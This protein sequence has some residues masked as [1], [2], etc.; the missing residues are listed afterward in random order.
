[1]VHQ[2]PNRTPAQRHVTAPFVQR[3]PEGAVAQRYVWTPDPLIITFAHDPLCVGIYV[4][5]ARLAYAAKGAV[6]LAARDLA[7]WMGH[8]TDA[9][10]AA[11]MRRIVKLTQAGWLAVERHSAHKHRLL[12]TWGPDQTGTIRSWCVD[13]DDCGKPAHLRGRRVPLALFDDYLGRLD[14]QPGHRRA[15][16]SR[17]LS[18]PLLDLTDIG[19][20]AIGLRA[21]IA[22]TPRLRHL[23]L[24]ANIG[25]HRLPQCETLLTHAAR[26]H[27]T[28]LDA[29]SVVAVQLTALGQ[30]RLA[31]LGRAD[32]LGTLPISGSITGSV[33]GSVA[34]SATGSALEP[35]EVPVPAQQDAEKGTADTPTPVIAWDDR[36]SHEQTNHDSTASDSIG[37]GGDVMPAA[38]GHTE[39][40]SPPYLDTQRAIPCPLSPLLD[41]AIASGH[42]ALNPHRPLPPGEWHELLTLQQTHGAVNLLIWQARASRRAQPHPFGITPGYYRACAVAQAFT[43]AQRVVPVADRVTGSA[44]STEA[45]HTTRGKFDPVCDALL[46]A[47]GIRER[48][49]LAGVS[50]D[51]IRAWQ[52]ALEHPG[53]AAHFA[54][55]V[56]FAV[57]QM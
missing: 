3:A 15:L 25:M 29:G 41:A 51:L 18:R 40:P 4:A 21:E 30:A 31:A 1:M 6:P 53:M 10:R 49:Q 34:R 45:Q 20:Y 16:I 27:L 50:H 48:R 5:V 38:S 36:I 11:I 26:G 39:A 19:V 56:G 23:E 47:M 13:A 8:D 37:G 14:P 54:T 12:P 43:A 33:P 28:T 35:A 2:Q 17:Y 57:S 46:R 9:D 7:A 32:V 42:L 24:H 44:Q 22:P 55:P 52:A